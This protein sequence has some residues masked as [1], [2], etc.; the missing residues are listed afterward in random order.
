[1]VPVVHVW[2]DEQETVTCRDTFLFFFCVPRRYFWQGAAA[3]V[4]PLVP[5]SG[6]RLVM[7]SSL[8][9]FLHLS[10]EDYAIS[11]AF[12]DSSWLRSYSCWVY[13]SRVITTSSWSFVHQWHWEEWW[14]PKSLYAPSSLCALSRFPSW[15]ADHCLPFSTLSWPPL[16]KIGWLERWLRGPLTCANLT[17]WVLIP[18]TYKGQ[19]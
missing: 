6:R 14:S 7:P 19:T 16:K 13:K 17:T 1:M 2:S 8:W 9:F 4:F 3:C 5:D 15:E 10:F 18:R 12:F 11:P